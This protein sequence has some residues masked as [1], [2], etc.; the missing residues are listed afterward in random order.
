MLPKDALARRIILSIAITSPCM[1]CGGSKLVDVEG[2]VTLNGQPLSGASV[3]FHPVGNAGV[4]D[5]PYAVTGSDG[6]FVLGKINQERGAMPGVYR[7]SVSKVESPEITTED[8]LMPADADPRGLQPKW[9]TPKKYADAD[10]SGFEVEVVRGMDA[11][12][13][14]LINSS[15]TP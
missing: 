8:G 2:S 6:V 9:H 1:G 4:A 14:S 13:L 15:S 3:T 7:V 5:V 10:S 12:E 11:V